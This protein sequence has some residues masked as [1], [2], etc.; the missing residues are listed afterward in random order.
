MT[1]VPASIIGGLVM[2]SGIVVGNRGIWKMMDLYEDNARS[3]TN[4]FLGDGEVTSGNQRALA[5][6]KY[7]EANPNGPLLRTVRLGQGLT[8]AGF[9]LILLLFAL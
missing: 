9:L 3:N 8:L 4:T 7:K 2:F 5:A 1:F 6:K